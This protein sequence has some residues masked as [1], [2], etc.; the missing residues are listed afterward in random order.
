MNVAEEISKTIK[1]NSYFQRLFNECMERSYSESLSLENELSNYTDK[2]YRDLLRFADLLS[3]ASDSESRNYAYKI[4]TYLNSHY[5][6]DLYYRTISKSVFYNLGNFPAVKYLQHTDNNQAE[7]PIDRMLQIEAKKM[8][9]QV[10]DAEDIYFTDTQ[11]D[12]FTKLSNSRNF[13]FSGPTSMGKSFIIKAFINRVIQNKPPE[14]IVIVVPSRALINQFAIEIN[15][16]LGHQLRRFNYRVFT[17]SNV[18]DLVLANEVQ[19]I[20]VLTPER[21]LSYLSQ[22][23]NPKIG[24]LFVDEAHKIAQDDSR[25]ITSYVAIEKTL[26]KYPDAKLYF[27]SPNVSNP[28]VLLRLFC[29]SGQNSF[30]TD[31]TTVAQNMFLADLDKQELSYLKNGEFQPISVVLPESATTVFG[32]L[33]AFGKDSNLVYC[34]SRELTIQYAKEFAETIDITDNSELRTA[35]SIIRQYIHRDY[36]LANFVKKGIAYHFGNMPQLIRNLIE[37]LYRN[38]D[39]KYVF[40]TSTL[41]EGVNMPT[42]NL[43]ILDNRQGL[44]VLKSIDFWNLAGRAGRMTKELQ[45]NVFCVKHSKCEWEKMSFI[46]N[47]KTELVP[48]VYERLNNKLKSIEKQLKNGEIK[49]GTQDEKNILRYIANIICIDTM[50]LNTDYKSPIINQLIEDNKNTILELA[51]ERTQNITIPYSLLN[52]NESIDVKIQNSV[53]Q[54]I[55]QK[56]ENYENIK[57]P[58][59]VDY[60]SCLNLLQNFHGL[61]HWENSVK[62]LQNINSMRY[63]ALLM[64]QWINGES[65]KQIITESIKYHI[66]HSTEMWFSSGE[67]ERFSGDNK[68]HVNKLI[69][70]IIKDIEN[71][72]RFQFE[73]Y[74]NHYYTIIKYIL[75]EDK[76]GENWASLLE[77]GTRNRIIIALQNVGLSRHSAT[78][79]YKNHRNTLSIDNNKLKAI[80][81]AQLL[82]ELNKNTLEYEEVKSIL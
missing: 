32:F 55:R 75:G 54:Q 78:E 23:D 58:R 64:C 41:L 67:R 46:S 73:K 66:N 50:Q 14:N 68:R 18:S 24:F 61:Y 26:K 36:Y 82:N 28:E 81:T 51:K 77:Y 20:L 47:K 9:Q 65:L 59:E 49:S 11:Y 34:N 35:S 39:I 22:N 6:N 43:F 63:Y 45:G 80:N 29:R 30:Q 25:S 16:E 17:N 1:G 52:S 10:P 42:Q 21:L 13:S 3:S 7:L 31:E 5:K 79:I 12:L 48:T 2:E 38:G 56:H 72:L 74:F 4:I 19:L 62:V 37:K 53:Y 27:S 40:C 8:I 70:D 60:N 33:R 76:A 71:I 44:R 15:Q 69:G 57:F